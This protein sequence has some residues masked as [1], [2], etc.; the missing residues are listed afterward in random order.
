MLPALFACESH[1]LEGP[2]SSSSLRAVHLALSVDRNGGRGTKADVSQFTEMQDIPV[3]RGLT[4]IRLIPFAQAEKVGP[5]SRAHSRQLDAPGFVNLYEHT[6]KTTHSYLYSSGIDA[7]IPTDT[8]A[9]LLYGRA[10]G[11]GDDAASRHRYGSLVLNGFSK[12]DPATL[13]SSL[14]FS[15][16]KMF[17]GNGTPAQAYVIRKTLSDILLGK[18]VVKNVY[19]GSSTDAVEARVDWNES[20]GDKKLRELYLQM[21]NEGAVLSG[22]G[23]QVEALLTS[24]YS[25]LSSY[26]SSNSDVYEVVKDGVVYEA[27]VG[28]AESSSPLLYKDLY[29]ALKNEIL[30][31]ISNPYSIVDDSG[32][33][34]IKVENGVVQFVDEDV[35]NYPESVGLPSGCAALRW[36]PA[37]FVVPQNGGVEGIAPMDR[38]CFPPAL[39]YFTNTTIGTSTED[40]IQSYENYGSWSAVLEHYPGDIVTKSTTSIALVEPLQFGVGMISAT[41]KATT[42]RLQDNDEY[43]ETTVDI[44]GNNLPV[45]GFVVGRQYAQNFEFEPATPVSEDGEYYLYDN[46]I[47]GVYLTTGKDDEGHEQELV[48]IRTLSLQTPDGKDVYMCLELRNDTGKTFYGADG[49]ILPGR[50]FYLVGKLEMPTPSGE[51]K[52]VVKKGYITSVS[53]IIHSL[54]G[55]YNCVPDLGKPQLV[56][57]VQTKVNWTLSTP[58]TVILE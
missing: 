36:T 33:P 28:Q 29:N 21:T 8:G 22:S 58:T 19:Y 10:P 14:G 30:A 43:V 20:I 4:D 35:R 2:D 45:T 41:V 50:K 6:D 54:A 9:L 31:F 55:A 49:R 3:F 39:Y 26:E 47:P 25:V 40:D 12:S 32:N 51:V 42:S 1:K 57:G 53:C 48:P 23:P 15:P 56:L 18:S 37:G 7:W 16:D 38:Y 13:V 46:D 44:I 17:E 27:R 5:N 11:S 24:L 34:L 52:S